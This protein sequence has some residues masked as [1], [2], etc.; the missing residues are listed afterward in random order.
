MHIHSRKIAKILRDMGGRTSCHLYISFYFL[1]SVQS[2]SFTQSKTNTMILKQNLTEHVFHVS[3]W[4]HKRTTLRIKNASLL[5]LRVGLHHPRVPLHLKAF[6]GP[7]ET[8][9]KAP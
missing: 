2:K 3:V 4:S 9:R 1:N 5:R 7:A 8:R 6:R